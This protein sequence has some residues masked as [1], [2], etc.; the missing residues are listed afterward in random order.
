MGKQRY[1]V[2]VLGV[3]FFV[4][5]DPE[6]TFGELIEVVKKKAKRIKKFKEDDLLS[7][8]VKVK[9]GHTALVD[10]DD[11][12]KDYV[13]EGDVITVDADSPTEPEDDQKAESDRSSVPSVLSTPSIV[14]QRPPS[15]PQQ[16]IHHKMYPQGNWPQWIPQHQGIPPHQGMPRQMPVSYPYGVP[17]KPNPY[18]QPYNMYQMSYQCQNHHY[19]HPSPTQVQPIDKSNHCSPKPFENLRYPITDPVPRGHYSS[20]QSLNDSQPSAEVPLSDP[21][22]EG[23]YGSSVYLQEDEQWDDLRIT[24][25][26]EIGDRKVDDE[27]IVE[28]TSDEH[29]ALTVLRRHTDHRRPKSR[30]QDRR[31]SQKNQKFLGE[32]DLSQ[33]GWGSE[34]LLTG[35]KNNCADRPSRNIPKKTLARNSNA[36]NRNRPSSWQGNGQEVL[37]VSQ[38][39]EYSPKSSL[40][41]SRNPNES[42]KRLVGKSQSAEWFVTK[43]GPKRGAGLRFLFDVNSKNTKKHSQS[44]PHRRSQ[45][46]ESKSP[47]QMTRAR[48]S[49]VDLIRGSEQKSSTSNPRLQFNRSKSGHN[50]KEEERGRGHRSNDRK[51]ETAQPG[52]QRCSS[53][54][55]KKEDTSS[56]PQK[57]VS[58]ENLRG[59]NQKEKSFRSGAEQKQLFVERGRSRS[60]S[61][62]RRCSLSRSRSRSRSRAGSQDLEDDMGMARKKTYRFGNRTIQMIMP[63]DLPDEEILK[64]RPDKWLRL[65]HIHGYSGF[66]ALARQNLFLRDG[67]LI[68]YIA[69]AGVVHHIKTNVQRFFLHHDEDISSM[70]LHPTLPMVAT[71]QL[72]VKGGNMHPKIWIWDYNTCR[73]IKLIDQPRAQAVEM[74]E[75]SSCSNFLYSIG[76]DENHNMK[77]WKV[78]DFGLSSTVKPIGDFNLTKSRLLGFTINPYEKTIDVGCIDSFVTFGRKHARYWEVKRCKNSRSRGDARYAEVSIDGHNMVITANRGKKNEVSE[79]AF[80]CARFLPDGTC[81]V[82]GHSGVIYLTRGSELCSK[83]KVHEG[84]IGDIHVSSDGYTIISAGWDGNIVTNPLGKATRH[85]LTVP[86][87]K[88]M[89]LQTRSMAY[90][91][92]TADI[93]LGTK[94][95]QIVRY[96]MGDRLFQGDRYEELALEEK[97]PMA[98][99]DVIIEGHAGETWGVAA[100]PTEQIFVTGAHDGTLRMW[101]AETRTQIDMV[102]LPN[103]DMVTCA[104]WS[105]NGQYIACGTQSSKIALLTYEPFKLRALARIPV[106][107]VTESEKIKHPGFRYSSEVACVEFSPFSDLIAVGH[108][109]SN[110]YIYSI[111]T[112]PKLTVKPW[113]FALDL[114]AGCTHLQFSTCGNW[115]KTFSKDYDIMC[116]TLDRDREDCEH[117]TY[118]I[119]PDFLKWSG[120]PIIAGYDV[121]GLYQTNAT[122]DG[123]GLNCCSLARGGL[124]EG[125]SNYVVSGDNFGTVRLF[126]YPAVNEEANWEFKGHGAFV[127]G[128]KFL[129]SMTTLITVGGGDRAI[130]QWRLEDTAP[131]HWTMKQGKSKWQVLKEAIDSGK[132][133]RLKELQHKKKINENAH[134]VME[135]D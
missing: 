31:T 30:S 90:D 25:I 15:T 109:D 7:V 134:T 116:W 49:R 16:A 76:G 71:G 80:H 14:P 45:S 117:H 101:S 55:E 23:G 115:L 9:D 125:D 19:L 87:M 82:G 92:K 22:S 118:L 1:I 107:T 34:S 79:K 64:E 39:G 35:I 73:Q 52:V 132:H 61:R 56:M 129:A 123:T 41:K 94:T 122:W 127:V 17:A 121:M 112:S 119:D 78:S 40:R 11:V 72:T 106:K 97:T 105:E 113:K 29:R 110:A 60:K 32:G 42:H 85:Y 88:N 65:Q 38:A 21:E 93:Y 81:L 46:T 6:G 126:N 37:R 48:R 99:L 36:R 54:I 47:R 120:D 98:S 84:P 24:E 63:S 2:L 12:L 131:E 111:I 77:V 96:K 44:K 95:N 69:C 28:N 4:A 104:A 103:N 53:V 130:F 27:A 58:L 10:E 68:Y 83:C 57:S 13:H 8:Q 133:A 70:S 135:F 74:L 75:F 18:N 91:E 128:C 5:L 50:L 59:R 108:F 102:R 33:P 114:T 89:P 62:S 3:K 124:L 100:H 66:N 51:K 20:A 26:E 43:K 67:H 86:G